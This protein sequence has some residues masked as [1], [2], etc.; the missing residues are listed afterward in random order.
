MIGLAPCALKY[1]LMPKN[2]ALVPL[3]VCGKHC[4]SVVI[5]PGAGKLGSPRPPAP[6]GPYP[7]QRA[8]AR[9]LQSFQQLR[10]PLALPEQLVLPGVPQPLQPGARLLQL[11]KPL[12]LR[13]PQ[14]RLRVSQGIEARHQLGNLLEL[15]WGQEG[16]SL[17]PAD[18]CA[19]PGHLALLRLLSLP[20]W[21]TQ[22]S[23][24][25]C[26]RNGITPPLPNATTKT[27]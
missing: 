22:A 14:R 9:R 20:T 5:N 12:A 25:L 3:P 16:D 23:H 15:G 27:R 1:F 2:G 19:P 4:P 8:L 21:E 13:E 11:P 18:L 24:S 10:S 26:P 6:G 17:G 7:V